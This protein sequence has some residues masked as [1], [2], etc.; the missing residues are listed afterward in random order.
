VVLKLG[1]FLNMPWNDSKQLESFHQS[2]FIT[3][4]L[5]L[6][7]IV[8]FASF[9]MVLGNTHQWTKYWISVV[10]LIFLHTLH[11]AKWGC[12]TNMLSLRASCI[13]CACTPLQQ[14]VEP[15]AK[16]GGWKIQHGL[17]AFEQSSC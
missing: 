3:D 11:D 15:T 17:S 2:H 4:V 13:A 16:C 5:V 14:G 7:H 6:L 8:Q 9:Q 10:C 12:S 1:W